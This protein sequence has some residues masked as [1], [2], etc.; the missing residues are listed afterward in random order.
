MKNFSGNPQQKS[1]S[2]PLRKMYGEDTGGA[3][4]GSRG[5]PR[6]AQEP[7]EFRCFLFFGRFGIAFH[8][9]WSLWGSFF[10][11][12][13]PA[14][15]TPGFRVPDTGKVAVRPNGKWIIYI[16]IYMFFLFDIS[17][18]LYIYIY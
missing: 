6:G 17:M 5:R 4:D 1:D 10:G 3:Q 13:G 16:Y 15:P 14:L 8:D 18:M 12:V 7:P 9:L 2:C 11:R